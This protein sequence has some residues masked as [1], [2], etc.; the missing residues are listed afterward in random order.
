MAGMNNKF[1]QSH[2]HNLETFSLLW[3]DAQVNATEENQQAQKKLRQIINHFRIFDN[4]SQ[5]EQYIS[6]FSKQDRFILIVSGRLGQ[7]IVPK[8]HQLRQLSAIYVYCRDKELNDKWA[9]DYHK[10]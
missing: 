1:I 8:I 9:K 3:L 10:V 4:Q 5:C 2:N 6:F 7:Q